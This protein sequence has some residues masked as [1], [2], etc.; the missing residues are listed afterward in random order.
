MASAKACIEA[1]CK[2]C[3]YDDTEPGSWRQQV[4]DCTAIDC[5]L[6]PV[7]PV[8]IAT[9]HSNRKTRKKDPKLINVLHL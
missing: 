5:A 2:W 6:Y 1:H 3:I 7:R 8:T 9:V 4:E